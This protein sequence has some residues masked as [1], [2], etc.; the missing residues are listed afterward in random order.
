MENIIEYYYNIKIDSIIKKNN[1]YILKVKKNTLIL[2]E[3]YDINNITSR[4]NLSN[5]LNI[6]TIIR[7]KE[8]NLFTNIDSKLYSLILIKKISI[9][10]LSNISNL[11]NINIDSIQDLE[12]NNWEVLWADRI[13]FLEEYISQNINKYPLIRESSDYFIGLSENAISYL[14]NTKREVQKDNLLDRKVISHISLSNS[15]YD[16][17]NIIFDHKARDVAEYIKYSFLIKN[18]NIYK[19]LDEY[20][21]HNNYSKYGIQVLYSR[22]LYPNFYFNT[23]DKIL[24]NEL[25]EQYLNT[26]IDKIEK[27]Q[28]YLYNI[29][30]YLSK[31][32]DIPLPLWIKKKDINPHLQL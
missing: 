19:E 21:K 17:F 10:T 5:I 2:K 26:T 1:Y 9:L 6:N 30:L 12:R 7:N 23:I 3:I 4:Y 16:P 13:D 15:L 14:V 28:E 24:N 22:V 31:Y 20:F 27:Y 32:Y 11:S 8:N 29:Y 25:K 18:T